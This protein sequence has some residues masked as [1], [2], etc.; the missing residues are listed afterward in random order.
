MK[1]IECYDLSNGEIVKSLDE[2]IKKEEE[3]KIK[4][5]LKSE[6]EYFI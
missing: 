2:A 6:I 1:K 4:G 3:F 5:Y